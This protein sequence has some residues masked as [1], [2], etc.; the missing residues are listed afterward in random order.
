MAVGSAAAATRDGPAMARATARPLY[1]PPDTKRMIGP[2]LHAAGAPRKCS[3]GTDDS[4]PAVS[5]GYPPAR[6]IRR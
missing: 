6:L 4:I 3:P 2:K 1:Q 5:S